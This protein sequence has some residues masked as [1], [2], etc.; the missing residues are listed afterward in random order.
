M[1]RRDLEESPFNNF[2]VLLSQ[3]SFLAYHNRVLGPDRAPFFGKRSMGA[4][5]ELI[6]SIGMKTG[7]AESVGCSGN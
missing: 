3:G 2:L 6:Q 5:N 7:L 4:T 1:S